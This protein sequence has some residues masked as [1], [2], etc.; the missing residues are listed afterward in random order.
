M[1][2]LWKPQCDGGTVQNILQSQCDKKVVIAVTQDPCKPVTCPVYVPVIKFNEETKKQYEMAKAGWNKVFPKLISITGELRKQLDAWSEY[3]EGCE[4]TAQD[5]N[6]SQRRKL[7]APSGDGA[8]TADAEKYKELL[9]TAKKIDWLA[10]SIDEHWC[11]LMEYLGEAW[12][13]IKLQRRVG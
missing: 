2:S 12:M 5:M 7:C 1:E 6:L 13:H 10:K 4:K 3:V 8:P 11:G 9:A